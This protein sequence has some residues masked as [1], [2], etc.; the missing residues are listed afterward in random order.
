M[1]DLPFTVG[2][3]GQG[4]KS[5]FQEN[6]KKLRAN[7][8]LLTGIVSDDHE[9]VVHKSGP[10]RQTLLH[11]KERGDFVSSLALKNRKYPS[12]DYDECMRLWRDGMPQWKIAEK[13]GVVQMTISRFLNKGNK[14]QT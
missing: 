1:F 7:G 6:A 11:R 8:H 10:R 12:L 5:K 14:H 4:T 3:C 9:K 2:L 13:F